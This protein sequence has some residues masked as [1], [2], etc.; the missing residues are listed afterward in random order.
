MLTIRWC[1]LQTRP[2]T[3]TGTLVGRFSFPCQAWH[4]L[5]PLQGCHAQNH[6]SLGRHTYGWE[7]L[8]LGQDRHDAYDAFV[9]ADNA[10]L[11]SS[12]ESISSCF[13]RHSVTL[14]PSELSIPL[15][16]EH[17]IGLYHSRNLFSYFWFHHPPDNKILSL[18]VT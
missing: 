12:F 18:Q 3:L 11:S 15:H 17:Q 13:S 16:L 1:E 5:P 2:C 9:S 14:H 6:E 4:C 8:W 7:F 10:L